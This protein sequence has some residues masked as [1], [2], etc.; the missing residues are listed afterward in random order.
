LEILLGSYGNLHFCKGS[1]ANWPVCVS[2]AGFAEKAGRFW[3]FWELVEYRGSAWMMGGDEGEI[4]V[5]NFMKRFSPGLI[6]LSHGNSWPLDALKWQNHIVQPWDAPVTH[7]NAAQSM[8]RLEAVPSQVDYLVK[9]LTTTYK[10]RVDMKKDWKMITLFIGANNLCAVCEGP[11]YSAEWFEQNLQSVL[12]QIHTNIPRVWV[13][14]VA[15]FNISQVYDLAMTSDY[16]YAMWDTVLGGECPCMTKLSR[17]PSDRKKMDE[18]SVQYNIVMH[19]L[20][21]QWQ[22]LNDPEFNVVVQPF[23]TNSALLAFCPTIVPLIAK[24]LVTW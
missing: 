21:K 20:A 6:G 11:K 5:G 14:L 8:A 22:A 17:P 19:K 3:D 18:M 4:S 9:Q 16:C 24:P 13:N 2:S 1:F 12:T 7:L 15:L 23:L 10:G